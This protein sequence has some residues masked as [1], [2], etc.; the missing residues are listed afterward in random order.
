MSA[1]ALVAGTA[2]IAGA[3]AFRL[4]LQFLLLPILARLLGPEAYGLVALAMPVVFFTMLIGDAGLGASLVKAVNPSATLESTVFWTALAVGAVLTLLLFLGAP[5]IAA[6]VSEPA[7]TPILQAL[8]PV[9]LLSSLTTVPASRLQRHAR[10]H[11]FAVGDVASTLCGLAVALWGATNGWGAWSLVAQ[12]LVLWTV[13][14]IVTGT[15]SRPELPRFCRPS[16]LKPHARFGLSLLGS[17]LVTFGA[18]NIDVLLVG[19]VMGVRAVGFYSLAVM[20]MRLPEM[21]LS[22]PVQTSLFPSIARVADDRRAAARLY[23]GALRV[24]LIV[25]AP[26]MVGLALVADLLVPLLFGPEWR[27]VAGLL[28]VLA[29]AG[30]LFCLFPINAAAL[31]GLGRAEV[32]LRMSLLITALSL[33][34]I[35]GGLAFGIGGVAIGYAAAIVLAAGPYFLT[36]ARALDARAADFRAALAAPA[37]AAAAMAAAVLAVRFALGGQDQGL[38]AL[39]TS[40]GAGLIAYPAALWL[41]DRGGLRRDLDSLKGLFGRSRPAGTLAAE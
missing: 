8:S 11:G 12:Q 1:R 2:S 40:I 19:A 20:F 26:A 18:R 25:A 38:A 30:A 36:T 22:G 41:L 5:L 6:A 9:L 35:L 17:N 21:V 3:N 37:L 10:F 24:M 14:V 7:L 39:L 23:F 31:N 15:L 28:E 16:L 33:A 34:G 32:Q 13:K 4:A 27:P 29:P